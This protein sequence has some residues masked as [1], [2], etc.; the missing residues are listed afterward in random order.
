MPCRSPVG[1]YKT[2]DGGVTFGER[3][4][5]LGRFGHLTFRCGVCRDCRLYKA[6]EWAI[7][8]YHE[9]QMHERNSFLTLTFAEDPGSVAKRDLDEFF[10]KLRKKIGYN[11]VRYFAVGEYGE[12]FSRPHYHV[13]LFGFDFPDKYP[14]KRTPKGS[15]VYRSELLD[16]VWKHGFAHVGELTQESAGYAARYSMKKIVGDRADEHYKRDFQGVEVSVTPEFQV[17]SRNPAVGLRWIQK[18]WRDV[19]PSDACVYQGKTV[20][21]PEY[22]VRWLEAN[23]PEMFERV[24]EARRQH[25]AEKPIET[26]KRMHQAAV[27]RDERTSNLK[28]SF[29]EGC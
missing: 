4:N 10:R 1:A 8:C 28:R 7:R 14:W 21:V 19:F 20:P 22:Y 13:C 25:Y 27:A 26:G 23:Q 18:Y 3:K 29:E 12:K 2:P 11:R 16:S 24:R 17:S 6:R 9:A 15:L 5:S